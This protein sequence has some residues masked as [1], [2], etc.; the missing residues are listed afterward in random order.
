MYLAP[1]AIDIHPEDLCLPKA[2]CIQISS[3]AWVHMPVILILR[4]LMQE[5]CNIEISLVYIT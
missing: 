5:G 4:G 1:I 3:W 2:S